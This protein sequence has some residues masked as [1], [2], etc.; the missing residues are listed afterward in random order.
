MCHQCLSWIGTSGA[1]GGEKF[2]PYI[3]RF[4]TVCL[5]VYKKSETTLVATPPKNANKL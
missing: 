3:L 5:L 4:Q 2:C 1:L